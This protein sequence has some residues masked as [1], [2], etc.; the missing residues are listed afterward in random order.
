M[1][2][3]KCVPSIVLLP[4]D[5]LIDII[6]TLASNI[7]ITIIVSRVSTCMSLKIPP[8]RNDDLPGFHVIIHGTTRQLYA[9]IS[10]SKTEWQRESCSSKTLTADLNR[11]LKFYSVYPKLCCNIIHLL[12][13]TICN[14][15]FGQLEQLLGTGFERV[16][17]QET[18]SLFRWD[19]A[20]VGSID[21]MEFPAKIQ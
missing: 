5:Y 12:S 14:G 1:Q 8:T 13:I 17:V 18:V 4:D 19:K 9:R 3:H 16:K 7:L 2:S 6:R 15:L 21:Q 11:D 20:L 10:P